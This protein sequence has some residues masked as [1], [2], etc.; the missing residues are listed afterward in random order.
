MNHPGNDR[1]PHLVLAFFRWFCHPDFR[2][3]IEGD[4][5]ERFYNRSAKL[6][7]RDAKWL[8]LKDVL[9]LFRPGI[10]GNLNSR[11]QQKIINMKRVNWKKLIG[12]NLL[13]VLIIVSPF[14]PGPSN[15]LVGAFSFLGQLTGIFGLL[16]VPVGLSW[17]II[18]IRKL[19]TPNEKL[20]NQKLHYHLAIAASLLIA[21]VF[22][23]GVLF[24]PNPMPK[25]SCLFGL[26]LVLSGLILA[27]RQIRK[28]KDNNERIP[29]QG[30]SIILAISAAACITFMYLFTSLGVF[31]MIGIIPG[32]L[33]LLLLSIGLF[34]TVKQIR[35]LKEVSERKFNQLPLYLLTVP[36]IAF[37]AF[38]FIME[39]ASD[40][41]RS[42][43]IKRSGA[44]IASIEDHKKRTGQYPESIKDLYP[45][46]TK[47]IPK[48]FI[49]GIGDFRYNK[50]NDNYSISFSQW[51][52]L[53][54]LEE[55]VLYD[56]NN[57]KD[58][59][60]GKFAKYDYTLDLC[61]VKGAFASHDTRYDNWR[62]YLVD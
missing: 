1:P 60:T 18:G 22:L 50:I 61:K 21:L 26:I 6:G 17:T 2:E 15:K 49:M 20:I 3:D 41:S 36:L 7:V 59:L 19:R 29:D 28:W 31:V 47:K 9:L 53:G 44:L 30:A 4:L 52:Q 39:P 23:A 25:M 32:I 5:L 51:L 56:K 11:S 34:W 13:V 54:S 14:I 58:N 40:F 24:L 48:P 57:L 12:L 62:Y 38:M 46:S 35:K 43:A 8:L 16:L 45:H 42:F 10:I 55:I 37:L 33:A 27:L